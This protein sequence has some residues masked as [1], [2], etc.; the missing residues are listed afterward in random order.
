MRLG[1]RSARR[2]ARS[3]ELAL[4]ASLSGVKHIIV[5]FAREWFGNLRF[6]GLELWG[7]FESFAFSSPY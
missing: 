3:G 2:A 7:L 5:R 6:D 1:A 4:L